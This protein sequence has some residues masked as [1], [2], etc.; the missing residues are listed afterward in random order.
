MWQ[1]RHY[2]NK[3]EDVLKGWKRL[4]KLPIPKKMKYFLWRV[5]KNNIPVR[6]LIKGKGVQTSIICPICN[7][8][9]EHMRH[10]F[11]EC[12][13][14][15]RCWDGMGGGFD[16]SEVEV[17]S[18]WVLDKL[19]SEAEDRLVSLAKILWGIW[20]A[21]NRQVWEEKMINPLTAME[22]SSKMVAEW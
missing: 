12:Q 16:L 6:N 11:V 3:E 1:E 9:V 10:V 13:F 22:I 14:A 4:W 20:F 17:L 19:G 7:E 15:R 2:S 21:R 5:C 8:D 18:T